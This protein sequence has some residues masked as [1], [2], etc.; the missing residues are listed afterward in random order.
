LLAKTVSA[1][2]AIFVF[3]NLAS[4]GKVA[5]L[6]TFPTSQAGKM[7]THFPAR[8]LL[9]CIPDPLK[10]FVFVKPTSRLL[11]VPAER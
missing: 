8:G 6:A 5:T 3:H 2:I 7:D 9:R 10:N 1:N 4:R 11:R